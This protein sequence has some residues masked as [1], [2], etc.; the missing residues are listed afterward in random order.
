MRRLSIIIFIVIFNSCGLFI[1]YVIPF[2]DLPLPTGEFSV[3]TQIFDLE[4]TSRKEW[5]TANG[6]VSSDLIESPIKGAK[7]NTEY[8][9]HCKK[10]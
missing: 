2:N 10:L 3:G 6:W 5:F 9:I 7:G 4:D 8:F 1:P